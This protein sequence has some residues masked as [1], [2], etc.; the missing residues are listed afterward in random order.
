[1]PC[2]DRTD[3]WEKQK[4]PGVTPLLKS[5]Q[6]KSTVLKSV[7]T[8]SHTVTITIAPIILSSVYA[9]HTL[10]EFCHKNINIC[11]MFYISNLV[12]FSYDSPPP[13]AATLN[14]S[15]VTV[16]GRRHFLSPPKISSSKWWSICCKYLKNWDLGLGLEVLCRFRTWASCCN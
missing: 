5:F 15:H 6:S 3:R 8:F 11:S 13:N 16:E 12:C 14:I 1:M 10:H 7:C 2:L 4:L 9:Y